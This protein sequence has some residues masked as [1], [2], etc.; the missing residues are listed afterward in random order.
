M[1][2]N[3]I[4]RLRQELEETASMRR[5]E[6]YDTINIRPGSKIAAMIELLAELRGV[7]VS[8][9]LTDDLSERLAQHAASD[10]RHAQTILDAAV[11]F[12]GENGEPSSSSAFGHLISQGLLKIETDNP[13]L[14]QMPDLFPSSGQPESSTA[15][16][17]D[18]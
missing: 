2:K 15:Q 18:T 13:Y 8:S 4:A 17:D 1:S 12:I 14:R 5:A 16:E 7:P 6:T 3:P 9:M 10:H 11:S